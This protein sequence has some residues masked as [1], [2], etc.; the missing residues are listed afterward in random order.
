M[1]D[2]RCKCS[3]AIS[4]TG[5]GCRYCQPQEY[6]DRLEEWV[7]E[8]RQQLEQAE[9]R[10]D[11]HIESLDAYIK[12][13]DRLLA[14]NQDLQDWFDD[15][16]AAAEKSEARVAELTQEVAELECVAIPAYVLRKQAEA[17]D[18][19][20]DCLALQGQQCAAVS[21]LRM[22]AQRLRQQA[23]ELEK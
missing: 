7:D 14:A 8:E 3:L 21:D 10:V 6:I 11:Q 19:A 16:R 5:D 4:L 20:A 9:A 1:G 17:V 15:A 12:E 2:P 23:D 18:S 13:N 22:Y